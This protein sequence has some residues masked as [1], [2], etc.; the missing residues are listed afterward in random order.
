MTTNEEL[1]FQSPLP[2]FKDLM[3]FGGKLN[4][5]N[6]WLKLS[7]LVPWEKLDKMYLKYF[8]RPVAVKDS[9]LILGM[10][11]GKHFTK[12][13]DRDIMDYFHENPYFQCFCGMSTFAV[14]E[15]KK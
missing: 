11:I 9:R 7:H 3:L 14:G 10:L 13:S 8:K 2:L 15:D 1:M 4:F 6:K 12:L 5:N